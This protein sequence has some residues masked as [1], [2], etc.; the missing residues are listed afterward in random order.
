MSP[1]SEMWASV[2]RSPPPAVRVT[3]NVFR[4]T[5]EGVG[6]LSHEKPTSCNVPEDLEQLLASELACK[7]KSE[8]AMLDKRS[9]TIRC[10]TLASQ[11]K[12]GN[13][14]HNRRHAA[15]AFARVISLSHSQEQ[16]DKPSSPLGGNMW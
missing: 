11:R 1:S 6:S 13:Q 5:R 8:T 7:S 9:R 4:P 16:T 2:N 15:L 12:I 10:L 3:V 14:V